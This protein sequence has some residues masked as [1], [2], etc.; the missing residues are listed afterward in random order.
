MPRPKRD[1]QLSE[2]EGC[3]LGHLGKHGACTAYAV[4]RSF[5]VSL[6]SHWSG[7]AGAV[8][9]A[10]AR[11]EERGLVSSRRAP[12]GGREAWKYDLTSSGRTRLRA[13][14]EP[15]FLSTVV[16]VPPDPLRTR[17]HFLGL[18]TP[19]KRKAFFA[20]ALDGLRRHQAAL[21][22][23]SID[24]PYDEA[25]R[26]AASAV[27]RARIEVFTRLQRGSRPRRALRAPRPGPRT[28]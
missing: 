11:L 2:L 17:L 8:Y 16:S 25:S 15:P 24:D 23:E 9:P 1:R 20:A 4:R 22:R 14:L 3:I 12:Q 27:M 28:A 18:M 7:S 13:W 26:A 6:S 10:L 5:L 19:S 21:E